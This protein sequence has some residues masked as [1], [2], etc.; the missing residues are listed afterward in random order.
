MKISI[1]SLFLLFAINTFAQKST[2]PNW[3]Y[4]GLFGAGLLEGSSP[5]A[6]T[7][8]TTQGIRKGNWYTGVSSGVDFYGIRSIPVMASLYKTFGKH[9]SQPLVY[10]SIGKHFANEKAP[11]NNGWNALGKSSYSGGFAGELGIGYSLSSPAKHGGIMVSVGYSYKVMK[12]NASYPEPA[13][14]YRGRYNTLSFEN[15]Y[16]YERIAFRVGIKI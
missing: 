4:F 11:L 9:R 15:T 3:N 16:H 13:Y 8:F 1:V 5:D 2:P 14:D 7:V 12:W 6:T 10:G